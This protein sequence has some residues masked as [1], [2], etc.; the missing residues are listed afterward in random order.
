MPI[1]GQL[2]F[3]MIPKEILMGSSDKDSNLKFDRREVF[4]IGAGAVAAATLAGQAAPALAQE[5]PE[6]RGA[7]PYSPTGFMYAPGEIQPFT[8]PGYKNTANRLGGNGPMDDTTRKIVDYV[9]SFDY[10]KM[11]P[12]TITACNQTMVDSVSAIISGFEEQ[13]ARIAASLAAMCPAGKEKA[14][15]LGYGIETTPEM[16]CFANG[17]LIRE[18]DFNDMSDE[19]G[20]VSV[21]IPAALAMGEALHSSGKDVMAAITMGYELAATPGAGGEPVQA[22]MVAGKLMGLDED[23]LA[24]ALTIALTPHVTLN[25]GVGALSMWKGVRSAE[26][27]KC[28]LWGA[29]MARAGMTGPPQPFE[30]RGG[31]WAEQARGRGGDGMGRD[32]KLPKRDDG[33]AIERNWF[34]RRPAEAGTQGVFRIMPTIR[35]WVKPDEVAH[36]HFT[37]SY[38]IWEEICDNPKW[39][40]TNRETA[41]HS[42]P[43]VIARSLLDGDCYLDSFN[44]PAKVNDPAARALMEKT[45]MSGANW[46]GRGYGQGRITITKKSGETKDFDLYDGHRDLDLND[47]KR[48]SEQEIMD[49]YTRVCAFKKINDAQRD[50]AHKLWSNLSDVKDIG[51]AMKSLAKFGQPKPLA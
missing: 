14:T 48:M 21:L 1:G 34:K 31:L 40:P 15:V 8:G 12:A 49:K 5:M 39:D 32:F 22:A 51:D 45:T 43:Y 41:D 50:Q 17:V 18:V 47:Y 7:G 11:S 2:V 38:G 33:M 42:Q 20:H 23:R 10:S 30:G 25:K 3:G 26:P 44:D 35:E 27:I 36:I 29:L 19:G 13:P 9:L 24:N 6:G 37:T 16:A 46:S 4:K 28:G